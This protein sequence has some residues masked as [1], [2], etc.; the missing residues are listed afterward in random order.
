MRGCG[1]EGGRREDA[2]CFGE[3]GAEECEVGSEMGRG[4]EVGVTGEVGLEGGFFEFRL[5]GS[6]V[7]GLLLGEFLGKAFDVCGVELF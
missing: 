4:K 1:E 2:D 6:G 7:S 3:A 5:G